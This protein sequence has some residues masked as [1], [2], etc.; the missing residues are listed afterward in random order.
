MLGDHGAELVDIIRGVVEPL[1]SLPHAVHAVVRSLRRNTPPQ[2]VD[3]PLPP[4]L[5]VPVPGHGDMFCRDTH[6]QGGGTGTNLYGHASRWLAWGHR[7]SVIGAAY[8]G[9]EPVQRL[10]DLTL[11][12]VGGRSTVFPRAIWK[13]WR[14]L[15][16]DAEVVLEVINGITFLTPIWLR[17]P[18]AALVHHVHTAHYEREMG[19]FGKLAGL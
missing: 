14:G 8:P 17:T 10:G 5:I 19:T 16:P 12:H 7:V 4:G 1:G 15:V 6:P 9:S 13:Q 3:E 2:W 11:Y 18:H